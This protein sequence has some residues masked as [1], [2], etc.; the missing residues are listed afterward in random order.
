MVTAVAVISVVSTVLMM[1]CWA[2]GW[3]ITRSKCLNEKL[4]N[5]AIVGWRSENA[6]AI[7]P[8]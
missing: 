8:H 6:G 1:T 7:L 2:R 3:W 5:A 4:S